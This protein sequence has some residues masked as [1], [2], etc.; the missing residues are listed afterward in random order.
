MGHS[1]SRLLVTALLALAASPGLP[2]SADGAKGLAPGPLGPESISPEKKEKLREEVMDQMR[3]MRMWK[4]TEELKLDEA[5]AA[6]VFPLLAKFDDKVRELGKSRRE[7][8]RLLAEETQK[9]KPDN[10]RIKTLID[11]LVAARGKRGALEDERF[12][13]LRQVLTSV[14]QAKLLLLLPR[15]EDEFRRRIR[16]AWEQEQRSVA[17]APQPAPRRRAGG[18]DFFPPRR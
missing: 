6:K 12:R 10:A 18:D 15:L 14:Q 13:A 11:E 2:A 9:A 16:E 1:S 17:G 7:A 3:A 4:L 5:T 8:M